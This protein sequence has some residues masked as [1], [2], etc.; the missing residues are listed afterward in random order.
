[1]C[2]CS[3]SGE[4]RGYTKGYL[5]PQWVHHCKELRNYCVMLFRFHWKACVG[6]VEKLLF[7]TRQVTHM[8]LNVS[9]VDQSTLD[10]AST[11]TG[12]ILIACHDLSFFSG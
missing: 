4:K 8:S 1:M 10:C 3:L 5:M 12:V 2:D 6:G 7:Y 11:Y 9:T